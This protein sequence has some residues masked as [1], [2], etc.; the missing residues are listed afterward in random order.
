MVIFFSKYPD[1]VALWKGVKAQR[2][3]YPP[4]G[5]LAIVMMMM[6]MMMMSVLTQHREAEQHHH[7][8]HSQSMCIMVWADYSC[9]G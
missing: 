8:H 2:L 6:M 7:H 1:F 4:N 5:P 9:R 3:L